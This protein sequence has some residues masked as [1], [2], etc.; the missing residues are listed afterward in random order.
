MREDWIAL[1]GERLKSEARVEET[2]QGFRE[3][4][5]IDLP[6]RSRGWRAGRRCVVRADE[7]LMPVHAHV[8]SSDC[9][10]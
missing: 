8:V 5:M 2:D 7:V 6:F 1:Q 4:K 9:F 10:V 3:V